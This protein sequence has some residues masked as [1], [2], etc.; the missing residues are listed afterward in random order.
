M[1]FRAHTNAN[2]GKRRIEKIEKDREDL[3]QRRKF[4]FKVYPEEL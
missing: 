3:F 4:F 1:S 2:M